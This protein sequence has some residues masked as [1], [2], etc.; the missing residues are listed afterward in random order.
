MG[1][2]I[3]Y[4]GFKFICTF[5]TIDTASAAT[6]TVKSGDSLWKIANQYGVTYQ[7]LMKWNNLSSTTIRVEQK[8]NLNTPLTSATISTPTP[9]PTAAP[10]PTVTVTPKPTTNLVQVAKNN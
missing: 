10:K 6:Y 9:K 7:T 1:I 4:I 3:S 5:S 8:L 2:E